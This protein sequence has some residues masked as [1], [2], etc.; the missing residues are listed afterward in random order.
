VRFET[1]TDWLSWLESC[2][3]TEI[4][5][6]LARIQQVYHRLALDFY[7]TKIITI[8]GTN[9]KGS[10]VAV[11]QQ[12]LSK[13]G[14]QVGAYTSPHILSYNERIVVNDQPVDDQSLMTAFDRVEQNLGDTSLSYFEFG[15]LA[16]LEVFSRHPLDVI[17]LEVG[18]GGRLDAVNIID[19]DIAIITSID[20]DHQDW[21]GDTRESIAEEKAGIVRA[22]KPVI[23]A[24]PQP[25]KSIQLSVSQCGA[26]LYQLNQQFTFTQRNDGFWDWQGE[27]TAGESVMLAELPC[28]QLPIYSVAAAIQALQLLPLPLQ[29]PLYQCIDQITLAGRFQT[30][31][32]N[33]TPWTFDVAHNPAA[34]TL[35][36]QRLAEQ[37]IEGKTYALFSAMADKDIAGII[38]PLKTVIDHW[39][40]SELADTPR[41]KPVHELESLMIEEGVQHVTAHSSIN[42]ACIALKSHLSAADRVI[43]FGSFYT[44]AAVMAI[45]LPE[46]T[47][48][49]VLNE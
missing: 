12:L 44:V 27:N 16:A 29:E 26:Q 33:N 9:G 17:L 18:L 47:N 15:T 6:G 43:I 2:H 19:S 30:Q 41:A 37:A 24:D 22:G 38:A 28:P 5:L 39:H 31:Q 42:E 35:L 48:V 20:L 49:G 25:P 8:A 14:Y 13:A 45:M 40:I 34:T 4:D 3:P 1:L 32:I 21:L 7:Q 46:N 11:L 23:C 10:C 36:A